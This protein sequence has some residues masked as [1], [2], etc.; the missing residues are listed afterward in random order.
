MFG[1]SRMEAIQHQLDRLL[2]L[3]RENNSLQRELIL[4]LSG[5][6]PR[7]PIPRKPL[8]EGFKPRTGKDVLTKVD[9]D[10]L[11]KEEADRSRSGVGKPTNESHG[12]P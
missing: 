4:L 5:R 12:K 11:A 7:T 9:L 3:Q 8:P 1:S 6:D 2:E 10:R